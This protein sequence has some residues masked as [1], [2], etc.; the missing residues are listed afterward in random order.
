M[1]RF[2]WDLRARAEPGAQTA[3]H[4]AANMDDEGRMAGL[5]LHHPS[6][7]EAGMLWSILKNAAGKTPADIAFRYAMLLSSWPGPTVNP[8]ATADFL[9][10]C[11]CQAAGACY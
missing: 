5:L 1:S 4:L 6:C 3:L 10:F 2:K 7:P 9:L 11:G 8:A